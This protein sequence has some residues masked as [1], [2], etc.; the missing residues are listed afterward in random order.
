VGDVDGRRVG[1]P[2][3][4]LDRR[5]HLD[6]G[7]HVEGRGRLVEDEEVGSAGHGHGGHGALKL[8]ARHLVR[9]AIADAFRIGKLQAPEQVHGLALG[10]LRA[11]HVMPG[12]RLDI[13]I[14]EL[15]GRIEGR[16][17]RLGDIGHA[18]APDLALL[19]LAQLGHVDAVEHDRPGRDP[20]AGPGVTHGREA[21]GG[22]PGAGFADQPQDLAAMQG[23][24]DPLHDLVPDVL[25]LALDAKTFDLKEQIAHRAP[26]ASRLTFCHGVCSDHLCRLRLGRP[27]HASCPRCQL[28]HHSLSPLVLWRNQSTTKLT[29][30]VRRAM[31]PAGRSGVISP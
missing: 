10:V 11:Q 21:D 25:A 13:L 5:Q 22:F 3:D 24:I 8:A 6:L 17:S 2:H 30:T 18:P 27:V 12:R 26:V 31:A 20:A 28:L 23:E 4:V 1:L 29:A 15:V 14:D 7:R 9:I 19:G 16:R